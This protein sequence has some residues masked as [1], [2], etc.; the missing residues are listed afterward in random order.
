MKEEIIKFDLLNNAKDSLKQV[1]DLLSWKD[2]AADHPRLKH[3]IL[4]AA[5]CVEL[6]LK[7]RIRRIN[8]AFVWEKV[9]QYPNLNA[10]TVT[11]DTAIVRLQ[12]IGN[13]LIDRKDQDLIRSLRITRN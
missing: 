1:I 3:A 6:L 4:G 9:D 5:H 12:N 10:R 7:E 2:I 8:P 11:V 13:V